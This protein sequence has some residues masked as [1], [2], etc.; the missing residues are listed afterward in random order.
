VFL[1]VGGF[2]TSYARPSIEDVE[3]GCRLTAAGHH[4]RLVHAAQV[5]HL[6]R[7]TLAS[8]LLADCRDRAL[9][10]GRLV[11]AGHPLPLDLNF[12][13]RD[14][15]ATGLLALAALALVGA[16]VA[17]GYW[18]IALLAG[19]GAG[20]L[21]SLCLDAPFLA[22][23]ARR[24][25]PLFALA[26]ALLHLAHRAAGAAGFTLGLL[27]PAS[28]VRSHHGRQDGRFRMMKCI[29][30]AS[31]LLA[32][33]LP[34][35]AH[36]AERGEARAMVA[37]KPVVIDYGRPLLQGRDMLAKAEIGKPWR[38]GA[39]AATTLKTE[40]DL[41]FGELAVPKGEYVLTATRVAED[42]WELNFTK[43]ADQAALGSVPFALSKLADNVEAL[44]I[45]LSDK[46]ELVMKWGTAALKT[47]FTGQ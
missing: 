30:V 12:T 40:A 41:K 17:K 14:R 22:F 8:F 25:S 18:A 44:T 36:G 15:L 45:E 24:V 20:M 3:L 6:K 1:R 47:T 21:A 11:R 38:M 29:A 33:A 31:A 26:A 2:D 43:S 32:A 46:G 7:W 28:A 34:A 42:K 13:A 10:W 5:T 27:V 37:G 35:L 23:A 39:D 16:L 9:P 19:A 4:I